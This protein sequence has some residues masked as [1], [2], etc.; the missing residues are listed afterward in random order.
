M[1]NLPTRQRQ[2]STKAVILVGG[3]N[4]GQRFRPLSLT[5]P[6][7]FPVTYPIPGYLCTQPTDMD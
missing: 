4:R 7:V 1:S 3:P 6:K 2:K 5:R